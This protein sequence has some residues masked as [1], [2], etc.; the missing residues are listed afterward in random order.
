MV[1]SCFTRFALFPAESRCCY[2]SSPRTPMPPE[3][4]REPSLDKTHPREEYPNLPWKFPALPAP[5][6]FPPS[7]DAV[8]PS[9]PRTPSPPPTPPTPPPIRR[10]TPSGPSPRSP[11]PLPTPLPHFTPFNLGF[12]AFLMG[13]SPLG[14]PPRCP[15]VRA[16]QSAK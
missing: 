12:S 4:P 13:Q 9:L 11:S 15:Q 14:S 6:Y 2:P 5:P 1:V 7:P 8:Q 16:C 10:P 3:S